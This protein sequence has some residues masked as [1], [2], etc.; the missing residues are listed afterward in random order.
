M[1]AI[2]NLKHYHESNSFEIWRQIRNFSNQVSARNE[3][4]YLLYNHRKTTFILS[5]VFVICFCCHNLTYFITRPVSQRK[6][7]WETVNFAIESL[8]SQ[9]RHL[10]GAHSISDIKRPR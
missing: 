10:N 1:G 8:A 4:Q 5:Y 3:S 7:T 6:T 2:Y 9:N